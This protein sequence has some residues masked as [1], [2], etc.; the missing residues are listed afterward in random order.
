MTLR[1]L[2]DSLTS[3]N[4][5]DLDL[6]LV[7]RCCDPSGETWHEEAAVTLFAHS[8]PTPHGR[9]HRVAYLTTYDDPQAEAACGEHDY[10]QII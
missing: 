1:E 2:K 4:D 3:C 8:R 5:A 9:L 7:L 6:E 10:T